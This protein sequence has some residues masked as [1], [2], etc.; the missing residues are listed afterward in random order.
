MNTIFKGSG[1]A[2]VTPFNENGID[3]DALANLIEFQ[4]KNGTDAI[5]IAGTT[6]EPATMTK[7]E[8]TELIKFC[9]NKINKRVPAI[10]GTG[11]FNTKSAVE[12]S[13]LAEK[14][15]ADALLVVTPYYNKCTQNGLI[16]Y[17]NEIA[18][19]VNIPIIAYSVKGRTGVN[20]EPKTMLKL[21]ENK[22][23][24]A[25]KEASGNFAQVQEMFHL[26][27]GKIDI[28]SG[29]DSLSMSMAMLGGSGVISVAS[30]II[31]KEMHE[32]MEYCFNREF[33]KALTLNDKLFKIFKDLFIEVNP[34]PVKYALNEMGFNAGILRAPLSELEDEHKAVLKATLDEYFQNK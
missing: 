2:L 26:L 4:I 13:V 1:V 19:S 15:G 24:V 30:N 27:K 5:I 11:S 17:Y 9:I 10:V 7:E 25:I 22:K 21:A 18:D 8:K 14:L 28:Y 3:Y 12:N 20:I 29:D 23:I 16:S 34:I 31:P 33:D 6:G 32:L